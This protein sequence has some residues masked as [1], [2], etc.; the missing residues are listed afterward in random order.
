MSRKIGWLI[1]IPM[2]FGLAACGEEPKKLELGEFAPYVAQFESEANARGVALSVDNLIV[3]FGDLENA[4]ER[5]MCILKT[6]ETPRIVI[7]KDTWE[8]MSEATRESLMF[9]ELG[10]CVLRRVHVT[11]TGIDGQDYLAASLMNPYVVRGDSYK[12]NRDGYLKELFSKKDE[13]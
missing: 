9:H 13:I 8:R 10:H 11:D 6:E 1:Y 2:A 7:R 4:Q 12:L 3:E 5:G